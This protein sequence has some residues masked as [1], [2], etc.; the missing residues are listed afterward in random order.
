MNYLYIVN[1]LL[2]DKIIRLKEIGTIKKYKNHC[3]K[4]NK[5][6]NTTYTI[7]KIK[8]TDANIHELSEHNIIEQELYEKII[9]Y[10][11]PEYIINFNIFN[12][13]EL[14]IIDGLYEEGSYKIYI[15]NKKNLFTSKI[16]RFSEHY[17]L[18]YF[19]KNRLDKIVVQTNSRVEKNDPDIYMPENNEDTLNVDYIFHTHPK[20]PY[21]GSRMS[22]SIIYEFPSI[23]DIIHFIEHHN[24]GKLLCS[25]V[26]TPEG[27]YSIR[28]NIFNRDKIKLDEEIF[29][30][31]IEFM[32]IECFQDSML[33][34]SK[35]IG[36]EKKDGYYK[37]PEELFYKK[38]SIDLNFI[39]KINLA[40][41]KYDIAIDFYPRIKNND[42][43]IFPTI[44]LPQI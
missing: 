15:E 18:L 34:F 9:N 43:W 38:I 22:N 5:E 44:H 12:T 25:I 33:K 26:I 42:K 27:I 21:L 28:K 32:Y 8:I 30:S 16:N 40:L 19:S 3:I 17:G 23:S 6:F 7:D 11:L 20:T 14:N 4:C 31:E 36:I 35:L 1:K 2:N 13:N 37:I 39:K 29:I 24:R 10:K 41:E